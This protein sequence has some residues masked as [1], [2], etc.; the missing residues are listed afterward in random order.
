MKNTTDH[1]LSKLSEALEMRSAR[2]NTRA[3]YL[4]CAAKFLDAVGEPIKQVTRSDVEQSL[5]AQTRRRASAPHSK[6]LPGFD[7]LAGARFGAT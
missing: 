3:T 5:L 1:R 7:S 6:H 2:P 4:R